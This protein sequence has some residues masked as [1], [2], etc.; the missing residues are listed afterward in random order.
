MPSI[1]QRDDG[2]WTGSVEL[3]KDIFGK[4]K[5]KVVY[6]NTKLEVQKKINQLAYEI[7]TGEFAETKKDTLIGFLQDYYDVCRPKW[8]DTTADLYKMY[9]DVHFNPYFKEMKLSDVKPVVLDKFYKFKLTDS[10]EIEIN[11]KGDKKKKLKLKPLSQNSVYKLNT[12]L[13]AA[14]RYAMKN[15][16]IKT[17][18]TDYVVLSK[19]S[20][21]E[22]TIYCEEQ[23]LELLND[24]SG[25]D[26]EIPIILGAGLGLRRGEIFGLKWKN[27]DLTNKMITI[28]NTRVRFNGYIEKKPKTD[29]SKRTIVSP[30]YVIET[31]RLYKV[32]SKKCGENDLV[33]TKWKPGSYSERFKKLL[34]KFDLPHMRL[35]DL[36]HYN[37][38]IMMKR[39]IPDK[40]AA[41]RLGHANIQTL[42]NV[43]QHVL[44]DMDTSAA[45][46][47]NDMFENKKSQKAKNA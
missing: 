37:A 34:N 44:K 16:L 27:V 30:A 25:T 12:F 22:P 38:V 28:E 40:V 24:V 18:P 1:Y 14:F 4:R 17:N 13:K 3:P 36:R 29:S 10:R 35:H 7:Q 42:R 21:Y 19:K 26:D 11:I 46:N 47:I 20:K 45:D 23:F 8:E 43:Y 2:K 32:R 15:N 6:G 33:I 5:R 39:G 9:I 31:L 41:Q